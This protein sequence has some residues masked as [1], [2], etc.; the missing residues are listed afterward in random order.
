MGYQF[1][2]GNIMIKKI[3]AAAAI[4]ALS[5]ASFAQKFVEGIITDSKTGEAMP[6]VNIAIAGSSVGTTSDLN[7]EFKLSIPESLTSKDLSFSSVGYS[8]ITYKI[9]QMQDNHVD[10]KMQPVDMQINEVVVTDKSETGR[11]VLKDVISS[12]S[13][14]YINSDFAYAGTYKSVIKKGTTTRTST[15]KFNAYDSEG[16]SSGEASNAF[17][18]LNYKFQSV[19]RDFKVNDYESGINYFDLTS[20]FDIMRYDLNVMNSYTLADF[21]FKIKSETSDKYV[22]E[23]NCNKPKLTNSGALKTQKYS[24]TITINKSDK[25]VI[26]SQYTLEVKDFSLLGL[27]VKA[28]IKNTAT[29]NCK[30]TYDKLS[31]KYAIKTIATEISVNDSSNGSFT[32]S[33]T[34]ELNSANYKVPGKISGK[35]F[36]SR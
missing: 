2:I 6:F 32:L 23:F 4:T 20:S 17:A 36:Y 5:S 35:V 29:I 10:I 26:E 31:G 14:N 3:L 24:G 21:D 7:G 15:Y 25:A 30:T 18:S 12:F 11:K 13:D 1:K 28:D 9:S 19:N 8:P 34:I 16:Y 27:S 22:I 33:D